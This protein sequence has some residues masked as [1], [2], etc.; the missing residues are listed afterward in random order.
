MKGRPDEKP[1]MSITATL[2]WRS[3]VMTS[4]LLRLTVNRSGGLAASVAARFIGAFMIGL[5]WLTRS[6]SPLLRRPPTAESG[7]FTR[8]RGLNGL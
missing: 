3:D 6:S 8:Q 1:N 4:R 2:G 5:W 7:T